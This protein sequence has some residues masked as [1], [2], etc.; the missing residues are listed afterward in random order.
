[1]QVILSYASSMCGGKGKPLMWSLVNELHRRNITVFATPM[2]PTGE[3]WDDYFFG[4]LPHA[5]AFVAL[6]CP[7][8][9]ESD[10]CKHELAR[11]Y[12]AN[13]RILPL[14][15]E[16]L[17]AKTL[18]MEPGWMGGSPADVRL[19]NNVKG[20]VGQMLPGPG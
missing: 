2:T 10:K 8:Y 20:G 5:K 17:P 4:Q 12:K 9:F 1:M 13:V 7:A 6:F 14:L 19:G 11:A 16:E 18:Q 15:F 3:A